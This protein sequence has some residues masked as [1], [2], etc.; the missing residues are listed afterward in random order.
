MT[1]LQCPAKFELVPAGAP[2]VHALRD[3][4]GAWTELEALADLHR[5]ETV[6]VSVATALV[7]FLPE[8]LRPP[9]R[10]EVDADGWRRLRDA[11]GVQAAGPGAGEVVVVPANEAGWEDLQAVLGRRGQAAVCQC[12]R[13]KL[14]PKESFR[15]VPVADR[16]GRLREQ[17]GAGQ[18][19]AAPSGDAGRPPR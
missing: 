7:P 18:P 11:A 8:A 9:A 1:D 5:G 10:W 16:A 4:G 17:T 19:D 3:A 6:V 2:A 15:A 13:F 12:Q 14:A